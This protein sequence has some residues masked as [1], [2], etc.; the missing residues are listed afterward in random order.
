MTDRLRQIL[1][2][3]LG[4]PAVEIPEEASVENTPQWDSVAHLNFVLS[5][6]QS[7]GV[8][9]TVEEAVAM[10]ELPEARRLLREKGVEP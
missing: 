9:L 7:F 3:T 4:V 1:A 8:T 2:E 5:V 6:E 10:T